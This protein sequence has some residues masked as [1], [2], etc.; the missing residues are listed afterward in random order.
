MRI[1]TYQNYA[2]VQSGGDTGESFCG[3]LSPDRG[4]PGSEGKSAEG[5]E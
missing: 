5:R 3:A 1:Q 2:E 4:E